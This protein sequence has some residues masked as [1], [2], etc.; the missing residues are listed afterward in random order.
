MHHL[1]RLRK[2]TIL[3][4]P[5]LFLASS[6]AIYPAHRVIHS[7]ASVLPTLSTPIEE[8][9]REVARKFR[10]DAARLALRMAAG[11][12]DPRYLNEYI[13]KENIDLIFNA[14]SAVYLSEDKGKSLEKCNIHTFPN[15]S[16]DHL[17]VIY[18][19]NVAW[20]RP[21]LQGQTETGSRDINDL[22]D[23]YKL[24]I[25][26]HVNWTD[27]QDAITIRS[28]DPLN[29]AAIANAF[30]NV[31]GVAE[32]DLGIPKVAG[33]DINTRRINGAWEFDYILR[34]GSW[35]SGKGKS[36][37]WKYRVT[38]GGK[39]TF[40]NENGEPVPD[41]MKCERPVSSSTVAGKF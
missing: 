3:L 17:V 31:E 10:R 14:L 29:M 28:K 9:P 7:D 36:H 18:D 8:V 24:V 34:F 25:E 4:L 16:I 39:V 38:D 6:F 22:L 5:C 32:M 37:T 19:K 2:H 40:V 21:L 30:N 13:S 11:G 23:R 26:K 33:N 27:T 15:P 20:A 35:A 12:E 1:L 41:W